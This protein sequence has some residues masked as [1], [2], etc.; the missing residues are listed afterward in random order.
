[1]ST[2]FFESDQDLDPL[3]NPLAT[4][5]CYDGRWLLEL[6]FNRYKSNECLDKTNV[7][8]NC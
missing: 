8:G 6:I 3:L 5:A 2:A 4:Y 7:Q 1:M